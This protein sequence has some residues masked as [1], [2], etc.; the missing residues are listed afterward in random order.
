MT[1]WCEHSRL[2]LT[3]PDLNDGDEA[4]GVYELE[5]TRDWVKRSA[6]FS[7]VLSSTLSLALPIA[8]S[9]TKLTMDTTAYEAIEN[10]LDFGKTCAES[11]LEAGEKVGDWLTSYEDT[12]LGSGRGVRAKGAM[13][14]E[15]HAL[16]KAKDPAGSFGGLARVQN[17]RR[18]FLWVHPQFVS[19]Y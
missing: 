1:L 13:L 19:E 5:L 3:H 14:R 10:Q 9:A 15:L 18:E 11:F 2:P 12:E 4:R 16:L 8:A 7:K 6:P 17:K